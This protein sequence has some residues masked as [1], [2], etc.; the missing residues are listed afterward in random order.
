MKLKFGKHAGLDLSE[1]IGETPEKYNYFKWLLNHKDTPR[2]VKDT[3][4]AMDTPDNWKYLDKWKNQH[5]ALR[6]FWQPRGGFIGFLEHFKRIY[7]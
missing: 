7:G 6:N 3:M 4:E 5:E 2:K 1:L